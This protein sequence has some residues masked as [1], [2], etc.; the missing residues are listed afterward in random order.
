MLFDY[1]TYIFIYIS[2]YLANITLVPS[3][4]ENRIDLYSL[5]VARIVAIRNCSIVIGDR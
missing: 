3:G 4:R 2:R 1:C 5:I